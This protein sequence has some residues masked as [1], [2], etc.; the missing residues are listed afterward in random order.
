MTSALPLV[1]LAGPLPPPVG[2]MERMVAVFAD[3]SEYAGRFTRQVIDTNGLAPWLLKPKLMKRVN[4]GRILRRMRK[5]FQQ[6]RISVVHLVTAWGDNFWRSGELVDC[7]AVAG[8]PV[9]IQLQSGKF[10]T[11]FDDRDS[12]LQARTREIFARCAA[13]A[14]LSPGWIDV[15]RPW[16]PSTQFVVIPNAVDV[17]R[18]TA[19][20]RSTRPKG[21]RVQWVYTGRVEYPKGLWELAQA[22]VT[23]K[24][25]AELHCYGRVMP[26]GTAEQIATAQAAGA[27]IT[28]HGEV[29]PAEIVA[30]LHAA[31]AFVLP[32]HYEGLP[33]SLI[34]A[35]ATGLPAVST[36][37]GA[38]P[39]VLAGLP[40]N[41]CIPP[42]DVAR[43]VDALREVGAVIR[44]PAVGAGNADR[45]RTAY[46]RAAMLESAFQAYGEFGR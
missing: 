22:M 43:L 8:V 44:D 17:T 35:L 46:S 23:L 40:G 29:G 45:A 13:V 21:E 38:I 5:T 18:F 36:Q 4:Q 25:E 34:E 16:A 39:E 20:D 3:A 10:A 24:D 30:G 12:Q 33:V 19:I 28:L 1:L 37:V 31:D 15:L 2:G 27:H 11:W 26:D 14:V 7:A 42:H 9:I 6:E 41:A 32:S